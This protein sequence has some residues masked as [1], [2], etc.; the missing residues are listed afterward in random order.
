MALG[1]RVAM[2]EKLELAL[3]RVLGATITKKDDAATKVF[4]S[5][6]ISNLGEQALEYY[7]RAKEYLRRGDWAGYGRELDKLENILLQISNKTAAKE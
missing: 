3:N 1:S 2:A 6:Q 7:K 4:E 5:G